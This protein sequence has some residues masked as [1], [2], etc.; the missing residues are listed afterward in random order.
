MAVEASDK[1]RRVANIMSE[2]FQPWKLFKPEMS[3][4]IN[5]LKKTVEKNI[6][7]EQASK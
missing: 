3:C 5:E 1:L 2:S 6:Y 4:N 7:I